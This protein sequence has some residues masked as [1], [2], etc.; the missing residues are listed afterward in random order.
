[1][2]LLTAGQMAQLNGVS[3]KALRLYEQKG[4]LEPHY[5]DPDTGYRYYAYEQCPV[6]DTIQQMQ[7][8]GF[9]LAEMK[10]VLENR[11]VDLMREVLERKTEELERQAFEIE[12]AKHSVNRLVRSC[13]L[14]ENNPVFERISLEWVRR[15]RIARFSIT[16]YQ[17]E[18]RPTPE[19]PRLRRWEIALREI[20]QQF[21]DRGLPMA[22]FHNVGCIISQESLADRAF[23]TVG[24]FITDERG[25]CS[26]DEYWDEGYYLTVTIGSTLL[27]NGDHAEYHWLCRLLDV[28]AERG[29]TVSGDYYSDMVL[30]SPLFAYEG[31]DMMMRL[32]LP[33]D[34]RN[35][36]RRPAPAEPAPGGE[37]LQTL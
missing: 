34:I 5:I 30:E 17:Y 2:E 28:A 32:Y 31:R 9:S 7:A 29:Y 25:F 14:Y 23:M 4:L 18:P 11:D 26:D 1:M 15:R 22:L 13:N 3:K 12:M 8:V 37:D 36:R 33:V 20:K 21:A 19:N 35:A 6:L 27:P 10:G 16:P 24:G